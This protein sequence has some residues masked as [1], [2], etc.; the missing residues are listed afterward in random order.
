MMSILAAL[1]VLRHT[2]VTV[3]TAGTNEFTWLKEDGLLIPTAPPPDNPADTRIRCDLDVPDFLRHS[4]LRQAA[5]TPQ[6]PCSA[7]MNG[8]AN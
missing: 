3:P 1:A 6:L 7:D 4:A 5:L 8:L 2:G